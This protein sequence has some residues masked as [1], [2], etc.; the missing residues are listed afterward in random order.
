V[1]GSTLPAYVPGKAAAPG[2]LKLSSNELPFEPLPSVLAAVRAA[3]ADLNRYP[4]HRATALRARIAAEHGLD[5]SWVAVGAGSVGLLQQ[6]CLAYAGP[7]DEVAFG[8]RSFE[9]YPVFTALAGATAVTVPLHARTQAI[10]LDGLAAAVTE[11]TTLVLLADPNNPS[12]TTFGAAELDRFLDAVPATT[13]VV[14]DRAYQEFVTAADAF[15]A[16]AVLAARPNV[17][18]LRT[19]SKAHGLAALRV[20]YLLGRPEIVDAV[21]RT[22]LPFAVNGLG[23]AAALAC[24]EPVAVAELDQRTA[25][26]TAE[27]ARFARELRLLGI[28][29]ADPQA[30]FVWVPGHAVEPEG[31]TTRVFPEGTR[32]TVGTSA[33]VDRTVAAIAAIAPSDLPRGDAP[34]RAQA[35]LDRLDAVDER[36]VALLASGSRNGLTD[37]DPGGEERWE[38]GQ[39]WAHTAEF[40]AYWLVELDL[41]LD[42]AESFGRTKKDPHRIAMIEAGR[43]TDAGAHL[44]TARLAMAQLRRVL[45]GLGD[46]DWALRTTHPTLGSMDLDAFLGHFLVGHYEEHADQLDRLP[47]CAGSLG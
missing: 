47:T 9:A 23:Q 5:P 3:S 16:A 26:I 4:D 10:D 30:N 6:L 28:P 27:R 33:D 12:G 14:L 20:G 35:W 44:A 17:C 41:I 22:L 42:G 29:V 11:R 15:D 1:R 21:D 39:A 32:I 37:P 40:G 2:G 36:L 7:G 19:F 8:W 45:A 13:L 31:I 43:R 38:W 24:L 25:A 34:R 18:V 46:D